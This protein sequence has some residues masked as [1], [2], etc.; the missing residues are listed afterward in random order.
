LFIEVIKNKPQDI[1]GVT[2]VYAVFKALPDE[3][4]AQLL[5]H[6]GLVANYSDEIL[7]AEKKAAS[8]FVGVVM[9]SNDSQRLLKLLQGKSATYDK[10]EAN[11]QSEALPPLAP[12]IKDG[13]LFFALDGGMPPY[14]PDTMR[15]AIR[16]NDF[17]KYAGH[18]KKPGF[19]VA[20]V[21]AM[22]AGKA[23]T[24]VQNFMEDNR[25]KTERQFKTGFYEFSNKLSE[26]TIAGIAHELTGF[27]NVDL[28]A[29]F[30]VGTTFGDAGKSVSVMKEVGNL[31]PSSEKLILQ[32]LKTTNKPFYDSLLGEKVSA[33]DN[34]ASFVPAIAYEI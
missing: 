2:E 9:L 30:I 7:P 5:G 31:E 25:F 19:S 12:S 26:K 3:Y 16:A 23:A 20:D 27:N 15:M 4:A 22:P 18:D 28:A 11:L 10:S 21:N 32:R 6:M 13:V 17:A 34:S 14:T 8:L 1:V 33:V 24:L 29:D